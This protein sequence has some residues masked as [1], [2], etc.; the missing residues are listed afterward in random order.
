MTYRLKGDKE[1]KM[2]HIIMMIQISAL[3][4]T[5]YEEIYKLK[6]SEFF[7]LNMLTKKFIL[8]DTNLFTISL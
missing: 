8:N 1:D 6:V 7:N 3:L 4:M 2:H 5:L